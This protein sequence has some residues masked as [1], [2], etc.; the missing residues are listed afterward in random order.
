NVDLFSF[1]DKP[2][3][4]S[5]ASGAAENG[6][7]DDEDFDDF[8]SASAP[9]VAPAQA[10]STNLADLLSASYSQP[11]TSTPTPAFQAQP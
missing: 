11:A 9:A 1:D 5:T 2:A 10:Q 3:A 4:T 7:D 6:D 8:Q